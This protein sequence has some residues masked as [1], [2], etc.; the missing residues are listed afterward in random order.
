MFLLERAR[1]QRR[2]PGLVRGR[3]VRIDSS[4]RIWTGSSQ[5]IA[6]GDD[7]RVEYG[8][9]LYS[10]GGYISIGE[11][12]SIGPYCILYG[13][14]GLEIGDDVIIAAH[15]VI[16]PS[17]HNF[18]RTDVPIRDQFT[19]DLGITIEPNVWIATHVSVLDGVTVGTGSIIAAGAVV[20]NDVPPGS[21]V[22][23]VPAKVLRTRDRRA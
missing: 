18:A 12:C 8:A 1:I 5:H 15:T 23:G 4:A 16:V 2:A 3:N 17:T 9:L 13:H 14:G 20:T 22:G 21:I 10:Y 19:T 7:S 11:R 6:I